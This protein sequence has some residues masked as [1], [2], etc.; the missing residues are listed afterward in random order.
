MK[1]KERNLRIQ[2]CEENELSTLEIVFT[3]NKN[4]GDDSNCISPRSNKVKQR[5]KS[6]VIVTYLDVKAAAK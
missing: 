1:T 4:L 3:L 6:H 5:G 2:I